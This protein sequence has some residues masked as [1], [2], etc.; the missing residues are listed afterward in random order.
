LGDFSLAARK[1]EHGTSL[2][3]LGVELHMSRDTYFLRP[4]RPKVEKCIAV[5]KEAL[6]C[7]VLHRGA[8]QK[9]A[10]RLSWSTQFIFHKLGRAMLRPIFTQKFARD[11]RI[12]SPPWS[13]PAMEVALP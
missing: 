2:V 3:V 9:L 5:I 7:G 8:A 12:A 6:G 10:G 13:R 11:G 4:S 1:L